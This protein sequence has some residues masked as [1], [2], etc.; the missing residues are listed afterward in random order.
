MQEISHIDRE[1]IDRF[2]GFASGVLTA[3]DKVQMTMGQSRMGVFPQP[4]IAGLPGLLI[5][6]ADNEWLRLHRL[7]ETRPENTPD[8]VAAFVGEAIANPDRLPEAAPAISRVVPIEEASDLEEAGLLR[9]EN[10]SEVVERGKPDEESVRVTL[11]AEDCPEMRRDLEDWITE[12][13]TP[14]AEAE[15]S[16]RQS[17]KLYNTLFKLHSA[18][19]TAETTPPEVIWGLGLASWKKDG[20]VIDMPIV[21]QSVDLDVEHGGDIVIF[22]REISG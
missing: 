20:H 18:I 14:W 2:L 6:S 7:T 10:V 1:A 12:V 17:I 8:H 19:R 21:E 4:E 3:R 15:R 16:V 5:A 13:W 22:P 11:L 9:R